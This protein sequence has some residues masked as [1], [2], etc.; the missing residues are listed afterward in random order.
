[1]SIIQGIRTAWRR[2]GVL[3]DLGRLSP[4][5]LRD[6]GIEPGRE[7]EVANAMAAAVTEP[8][9]DERSSRRRQPAGYAR[10]QLRCC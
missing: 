1:M 8:R 2:S 10:P 6:I 4:A 5:Q 9:G 7:F 3:G